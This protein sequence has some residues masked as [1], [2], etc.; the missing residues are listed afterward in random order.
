MTLVGLSLTGALLMSSPLLIA[1][2][3]SHAH[4]E[5]SAEEHI[6]GDDDH[7]DMDHKEGE[8]HD[9]SGHN[10][11]EDHHGADHADH[12][13]AEHG[14]GKVDSADTHQEA[15]E[16]GHA[17]G[18]HG[19]HEEE[20]ASDVELTQAQ[21]QQAG[22]KTLRLKKQRVSSQ[23]SALSEV[24]L[25][26]Y[27]TTQVSPTITTRIEKRHVRLGDNVKK[28]DLLVTLHTIETTDISAN[29]LATADLAAS[30]A[31]LAVSIAE[32]K[33][34]L[35]AATATWNRIRSLGRDAV[36]GKRYVEAKIAKE[37]A[38]AKLKAFGKSQSKV[39]GLF[40]SGSKAVQKHFKL[41][42][43]Q[44]GMVIKDDFVLGQVVTPEDVLFVISDVGKLW[45]EANIKPKEVTNIR[46]GARAVIK[47]AD[48][49]LQGKVIHIGRVLNEST[50][51]LPVRIE[52]NNRDGVLYPGQFVKT[53]IDTKTTKAAITIPAEAVLRSPDGDWMLFVEEAPGRFVPKEVEIVEN[54]G[55]KLVVS[56][57]ESG[58]TIVSKGAFT[59]QSELAKSGFS[60]HNH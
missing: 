30:S 44:A 43:E 26:Q 47:V 46:N 32:A 19:D 18:G 31:A 52:V 49:T 59:I 1:E 3:Q 50:R 37:Q 2:N 17:H 15:D 55:D 29:M 57:V 42:A 8:S 7:P 13:E 38:E 34:E 23:I 21:I 6:T 56:G 40:K 28:G 48:K 45:V 14:H 16:Q 36:S 27:R 39:N 53:L 54:L 4:Q 12:N 11:E 25:N 5:K 10:K 41:R 51:T 35:A 60:V 22:I 20:G 58:T 24:K 33:G 9:E